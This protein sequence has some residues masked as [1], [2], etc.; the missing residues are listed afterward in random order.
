MVA[1]CKEIANMWQAKDE[2]AQNSAQVVS[3]LPR[4]DTELRMYTA[5]PNE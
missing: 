3:K 4:D 2:S 5:K 1:P